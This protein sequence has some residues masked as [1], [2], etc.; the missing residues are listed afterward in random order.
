MARLI[1][2]RRITAPP[3]DGDFKEISVEEFG[4]TLQDNRSGKV[5]RCCIGRDGQKNWFVSTPP[6]E[7]ADS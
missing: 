2:E 3:L 4:F 6:Q 7:V 1:K 5:Y